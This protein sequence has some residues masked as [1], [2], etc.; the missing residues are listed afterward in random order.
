MMRINTQLGAIPVN[1]A[2]GS[3]PASPPEIP[4]N[5]ERLGDELAELETQ[6]GI[7][8]ARLSPV[9]SPAQLQEN[10]VAAPSRTEFGSCV[11][12]LRARVSD[13]SARVELAISCLEL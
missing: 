7:F 11:V 8:I 6:L 10:A 3:N 9:L 1:Q 4:H 12:N 13:L 2:Q 5:L